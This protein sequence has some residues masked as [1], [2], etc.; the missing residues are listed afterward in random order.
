[1]K[2]TAGSP[3]PPPDVCCV[4]GCDAPTLAL[5]LCNR[6]WRR[7]RKY[8]SP[9]ATKGHSGMMVGLAPKVRFDRQVKR[10]P[11]C[12]LW[13][14][15]T[16]RDGYGIFRGDVGGIT[17]AKAHRYSWA[18]HTGEVLPRGI[19]VC[20]K[21]DN[22]RC[23]NPDHL[24]PGTAADNMIDKIRKGRANVPFGERAPTARLT[25]KQVKAIIRDPRPHAQIAAD[26]GVAATTIGSVKQRVSWAWLKAGPVAR[27]PKVG[28][29]GERN[30]HARLT[31]ADIR[32]IRTTTERGMDLAERYGVTRAAITNIRKRRTWAHVK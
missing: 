26:Y 21:C 15:A 5:G 23:V 24:F 10:T 17:Y 18:F 1:V 28:M 2:R 9:V 30:V 7:T 22:P 8:G 3:N 11:T 32:H 4:K 12:W 27:A 13:A 20:H 16:D 6:H 29:R 25:V 19:M 31:E 14:G